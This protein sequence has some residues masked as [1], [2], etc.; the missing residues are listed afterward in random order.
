MLNP[1]FHLPL[2]FYILR[3]LSAYTTNPPGQMQALITL[4]R[5]IHLFKNRFLQSYLRLQAKN[6]DIKRIIKNSQKNQ[7]K[8]GNLVDAKVPLC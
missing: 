1:G 2:T 8:F 5:Q 4:S 3:I 6:K 7:Q